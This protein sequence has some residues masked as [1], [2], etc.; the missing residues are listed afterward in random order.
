[1]RSRINSGSHRLDSNPGPHTGLAFGETRNW[2]P[3]EFSEI[4]TERITEALSEREDLDF[5]DSGQELKERVGLKFIAPNQANTEDV[6]LGG[7]IFRFE[8]GAH[9][10]IEVNCNPIDTWDNPNG[11]R[12]NVATGGS[13]N[14]QFGD[15]VN[16][17][18]NLELK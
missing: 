6:N 2:R 1:L 4:P 10:I 17:T 18:Y 8:N 9:R 15:D 13:I 14:I 5:I 16:E 7:I 3:S 11:D 12:H